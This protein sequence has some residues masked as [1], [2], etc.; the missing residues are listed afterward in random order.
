MRYSTWA[1]TSGL[2]ARE[3]DLGSE[4]TDTAARLPLRPGIHDQLGGKSGTNAT[5]ADDRMVVRSLYRIDILVRNVG[6][7]HPGPPR[8]GDLHGYEIRRQLR[9]HLGLLANVSFGSIYPALTRLEKIGRRRGHRGSA[10]PDPR[11]RHRR[12]PPAP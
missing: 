2:T 6:S 9:E 8:G 3:G 10:R 5:A 12:R 7:G 1:V 4:V 11:R